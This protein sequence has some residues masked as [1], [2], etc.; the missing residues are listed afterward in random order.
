LRYINKFLENKDIIEN[1][2]T[3]KIH[4]YAYTSQIYK[5]L[6]QIDKAVELLDE[7][8]KLKEFYPDFHYLKYEIYKEKRKRRKQ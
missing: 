1:D 4:F 6:N 8:L 5:L 2:S 3:F 7:G